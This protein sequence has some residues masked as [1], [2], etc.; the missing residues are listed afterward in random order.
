[1]IHLSTMKPKSFSRLFVCFEFAIIFEE[2]IIFLTILSQPYENW[3]ELP[4]GIISLQ[5]CKI[6]NNLKWLSYH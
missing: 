1:M 6:A 4:R 2:L 3:S 5:H